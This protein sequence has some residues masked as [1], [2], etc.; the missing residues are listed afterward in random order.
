MNHDIYRQSIPRHQIVLCSTLTVFVA[1]HL[2]LHAGHLAFIPF[3]F[4]LLDVFVCTLEFFLVAVDSDIFG[5]VSKV[6]CDI[7]VVTRKSF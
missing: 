1:I 7:V 5:I 6:K 4:C 3:L 2:F